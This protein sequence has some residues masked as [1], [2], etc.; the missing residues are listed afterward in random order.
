MQK[1]PVRQKAVLP[2][3]QLTFPSPSTYTNDAC[4]GQSPF[5]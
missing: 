3:P 2:E 1:N 5:G 4:L